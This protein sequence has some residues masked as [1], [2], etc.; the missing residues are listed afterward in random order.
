MATTYY[1]APVHFDFL[2]TKPSEIAAQMSQYLDNNQ[3]TAISFY[4]NAHNLRA[5]DSNG[6]PLLNIYLKQN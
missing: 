2:V 1:D 4:L 6:N 5:A 3:P